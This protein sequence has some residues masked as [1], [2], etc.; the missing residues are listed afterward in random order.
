MLLVYHVTIKIGLELIRVSVD[1][2]YT[3]AYVRYAIK[4]RYN[5]LPNN[6]INRKETT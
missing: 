3:L 1:P 5:M 2:S 6:N 4:L